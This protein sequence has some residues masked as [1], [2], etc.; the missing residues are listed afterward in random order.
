M[1]HEPGIVEGTL[2]SDRADFQGLDLSGLMGWRLG[3]P[4]HPRLTTI[5][6]SI[7]FKAFSIDD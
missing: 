3:Y 5:I 4:E 1:F 6:R 7:D 2:T